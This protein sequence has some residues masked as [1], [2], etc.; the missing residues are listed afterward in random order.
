MW[1][2]YK[3]QPLNQRVLGNLAR[4]QLWASSPKAFNDPFELRL[5]RVTEAKGVPGIRAVNP[6]LNNLPDNKV[7]QKAIDTYQDHISKFAVVCFTEVYDD[8]LMWSH[9]ADHH[10]GICIGFRARDDSQTAEETQIYKV[11]YAD[12]YP[13]L[14]F[15]RER[16]WTREGIAGVLF[17]K[18]RAWSYEKEWRWIRVNGEEVV[19]YPGILNKIIFGLRT[20]EADHALVRAIVK[21]DTNVTFYKVEQDD[22]KYKLHVRPI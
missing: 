21:G 15:S 18:F 13:T 11:E 6:E 5:P 14:D 20:T 12:E 7:V 1:E 2:L 10:K 19:E 16:V 3:Y 17:S 9:Y 8:L 22:T 4:R